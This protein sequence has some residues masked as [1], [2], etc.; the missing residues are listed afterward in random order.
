MVNILPDVAA[1]MVGAGLP[2][3]LGPGGL[4]IVSGI[5][6]EQAEE[7]GKAMQEM[8]L[9]LLERRDSGAWTALVG[10]RGAAM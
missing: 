3:W 6:L 9:E 1:G 10:Q 8:G 2:R 5:I 7:T 4:L